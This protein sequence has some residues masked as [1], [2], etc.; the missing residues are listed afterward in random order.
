MF[1]H[2]S[3][4]NAISSIWILSLFLC[5]PVLSADETQDELARLQ[6]EFDTTDTDGNGTISEIEYLKRK[7]AQKVLKRDFK[8]FD[9]NGDGVLTKAEFSVT[10]GVVHPALRGPL[11]DPIEGL[12]L[13]AIDALDES[14]EGWSEKPEMT[15][16]AQNFVIQYLRSIS[17]DNRVRYDS[18]LMTLAD[19]NR[20]TQVDWSEA[21]RFLEIQLGLRTPSGMLLREP[22]GRLFAYPRFR[23]HD[24]NKDGSVSRQEYLSKVKNP[25]AAA[26]FDAGDI[27][28][29]GVMSL[30]ET[31]HPRWHG[32]ED[33]I[34]EFRSMDTDFDGLVSR[35][36]MQQKTPEFR[37][38]LI[39]DT[40]LGFDD[41]GDGKIRLDEFRLSPMGNRVC[42]WWSQ[43]KD[44]NRDQKI[45][46]SEFQWRDFENRLL[47]RYYF[48]IFDA[49]GDNAL[50][51][52]EYEFY[53]VP[54][55]M[56][57]RLSLETNQVSLLYVNEE[58][59]HCGS[60][61]VS[62]DGT[63]I[64]FDGWDSGGISTSRI[65]LA[66]S[67]GE[68]VRNLVSG[69][70]PTWS[71]DGKQFACSRYEDG[72]SVWIMNIDGSAEKKIDNGWGA[73][74]SPD[75]QYIAYTKGRELFFY[76]V[77][78]GSSQA[79]LTENDH[80]Y[81]YMYYNMAWSADS[82]RLAFKA[83]KADS[84]ISDIVS[85]STDEN[86]HDLRV[87]LT[88]DKNP[89]ADMAWFPDGKH[90]LLSLKP[91]DNKGR[92]LY[93]LSIEEGSE[94]EL[95]VETEND[96]KF[97]GVTISPDGKWAVIATAK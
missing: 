13:A 31:A 71:P 41:D 52:E 18:N 9:F 7:G 76:E 16:H 48:S 53:R 30:Q 85:I 34:L 29:D 33:P 74:W 82:S 61:A 75:G 81:R 25:V 39:R 6:T 51:I 97:N 65:F 68:N 73:Q 77:A 45:E 58:Y 23:Y 43:I 84:A 35:K 4:R 72:S 55:Q 19:E 60:P 44:T 56:L 36:E 27:N 17:T 79:I 22:S 67:E 20:N 47:W 80:E 1:S 49:D 92:I 70:M 96:L 78:K 11:P 26:R 42:P 94:P 12:R 40:Y 15:V 91:S 5:P 86:D 3:M 37:A 66:T 2:V 83:Y 90:L 93:K 87:H 8:L 54:P 50:T 69:L 57:H 46:F 32:Y 10:P 21:V 95:L 28:Q 62:P 14:F 38:S 24:A 63:K 88:T 64:L 89:E 59:P